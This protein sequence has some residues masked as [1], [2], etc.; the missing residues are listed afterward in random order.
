MPQVMIGFYS[1][2]SSVPMGSV[3]GMGKG[4]NVAAGGIVGCVLASVAVSFVVL[5]GTGATGCSEE[6][7]LDTHRKPIE[8]VGSPGALDMR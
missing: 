5:A 7:W 3:V 1:P 2:G 6:V 4:V 8:A